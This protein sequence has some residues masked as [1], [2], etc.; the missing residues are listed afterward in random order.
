MPVRAIANYEFPSRSRQELYGGDLLV[1]VMW[2]GN[3]LFCAAACFRAPRSMP[4][5]DFVAAMVEPWAG[6]DP[7]FEP[8]SSHGWT[9]DDRPVDPSPTA[10]LADLG[11]G[12]K[13]LITFRA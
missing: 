8:G 5:Q 9:V 3:P 4:W 6:N 1:N 13:S 2:R 12:H 10:T 7:D 11:V